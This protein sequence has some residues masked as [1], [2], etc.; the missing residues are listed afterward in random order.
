MKLKT[1]LEGKHQTFPLWPCMKN[2]FLRDGVRIQNDNNDYNDYDNNEAAADD[3]IS[4][5]N[6]DDK[7]TF[8]T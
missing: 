5:Y 6:D 8:Y 1:F 2:D 3:T 7:I 4:H